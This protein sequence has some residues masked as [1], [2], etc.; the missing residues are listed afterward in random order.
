[1]WYDILKVQVLGSKQKVKQGIKPLPKN[2]EDS[3]LKR[4]KECIAKLEALKNKFPPLADRSIST[5]SMLLMTEESACK[6][7]K[8]FKA[9]GE[10]LY[11]DNSYNTK[12]YHETLES[13]ILYIS[14]NIS[15]TTLRGSITH[16]VLFIV[17]WKFINNRP[18][19]DPAYIGGEWHGNLHLNWEKENY[20]E[21]ELDNIIEELRKICREA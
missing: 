9:A 21:K 6:L 13:P 14:Y 12:P 20:S 7:L 16:N 17:H 11:T 1:M 5:D 10:R 18:G 8:E 2:E 4:L 3:C 19:T 15:D